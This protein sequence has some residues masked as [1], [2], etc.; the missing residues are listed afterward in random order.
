L[1]DISKLSYGQA[2]QRSF[3]KYVGDSVRV[4]AIIEADILVVMKTLNLILKL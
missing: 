1:I 2:N 3:T 4:S